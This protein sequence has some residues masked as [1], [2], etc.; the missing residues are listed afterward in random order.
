LDQSIIS[1]PKQK[2]TDLFQFTPAHQIPKKKTPKGVFFVSDFL[3]LRAKEI[4]FC[5]FL[6]GRFPK[7][8]PAPVFRCGRSFSVLGS[9][10]RCSSTA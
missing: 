6:V 5:P 7:I 1:Q 2:D 9:V 3:D 10:G 8:L 4:R